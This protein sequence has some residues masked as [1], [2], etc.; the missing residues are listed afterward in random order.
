MKCPCASGLNYSACCEKILKGAAKAE[1]AEALMRSRYTAYTLADI[2]YIEKTLAPES[3]SDFD[4]DATRQWA[5]ES[6]WKGL[7]ILST[8]QGQSSDNKGVVE[9]IA[10][11]VKNGSNE[12]HHER[13]RFRKDS[14]GQWLFID[15]NV[16]S[17]QTTHLR[18]EAKIGRNDPCPCGSG[19]KYKKC[20]AA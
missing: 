1:T 9:F 12:E 16:L 10:S 8:E 19:K 11:Y 3:R 18:A 6:E 17:P 5:E 13:S 14:S 2:A 7:K 20:C 4:A 15:G